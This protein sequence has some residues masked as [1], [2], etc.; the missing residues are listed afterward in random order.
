MVAN[1]AGARHPRRDCRA[2]RR[3]RRRRAVPRA[4]AL[5]RRHARRRGAGHRRRAASTCSCV[6]ADELRREAAPERAGRRRRAAISTTRACSISCGRCPAATCSIAAGRVLA[7]GDPELAQRARARTRSSASSPNGTCVRSGRAAAIRSAARRST[8]WATPTPARTGA[9]ATAPTSSATPTTGCAGSTITT[10]RC[11]RRP[12][13]GASVR[14]GAPRLPR[15]RAA[16]AP[17]PSAGALGGEDAAGPR[18]R[19]AHHHRRAAAGARRADPA[20]RAPRGRRPGSAAAVVLDAATGDVLALASYPFPVRRPSGAAGA[21][22]IAP[23]RCFDRA[24]YGL[25]PPGSTFKLVTAAAAL[26]QD[27]ALRGRPTAAARCPTGASACASPAGRPVRDDVLD[28]HPH[29]TIGMHDG[30]VL[31]CNAYFAQ[32][33]LKLGPEAL[34]DAAAA[35]G[36]CGD[37]GRARSSALRATLPQA[38]YGQGDVRGQPAAHGARGGGAGQRRRAHRAARRDAARPGGEARAAAVAAGGAPR[39]RRDMRDGV[40]DGT[41]RGL[42]PHPMRI[43]GK[44]GTAEVAGEPVA[45]V[46]RRLRAVRRGRRRRADRLC[47]ARRERRLRRPR[48]RGA[49][50][51][52]DR[53]RAA[54]RGRAR[55][56]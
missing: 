23:R 41:G 47:R 3:P 44:T 14:G 4:D 1:F 18:P 48:G 19:R 15:A 13:S 56:E 5:S 25:Y 12:P 42:R 39:S 22:R 51:R 45:L 8:C 29:G 16:A 40:L 38:A 37:A 27:P 2:P 9:R 52:R 28:R 50:R 26:R 46:V 34:L 7:T 32:L 36:I 17:P 20:E 33:A 30:L 6:R 10:C 49:G 21:A 11:R 35:L 24:R 53:R 54:G 43:A 55:S 31:S